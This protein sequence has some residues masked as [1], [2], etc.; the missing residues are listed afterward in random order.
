M[1]IDSISLFHILYNH[2]WGIFTH[3]YLAWFHTFFY[4]KKFRETCSSAQTSAKYV[5]NSLPAGSV[6]NS[7][8]LIR[9]KKVLLSAGSTFLDKYSI[10]LFCLQ[11]MFF[12]HICKSGTNGVCQLSVMCNRNQG[13]SCIM[14]ILQKIYQHILCFFIKPGKWFIKNQNLRIQ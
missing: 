10:I 14:K 13:F 9:S 5:S 4:I 11:F 3:S 8:H 7:F 12:I 1:N 2:L 6:T